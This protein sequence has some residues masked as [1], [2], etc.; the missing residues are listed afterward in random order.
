MPRPAAESNIKLTNGDL[1]V[2]DKNT[3]SFNKLTN[4]YSVSKT[5]RF[6]LRPQF[7]TLEHIKDNKII[8]KGEELKSHYEIFKKILDQVFIKLIDDSLDHTYFDLKLIEQFNDLK[9]KP[10]EQF[11]E[12]DATNL[13]SLKDVMKKQIDKNLDSPEKKSIFK[14]PANFLLDNANQYSNIVDSQQQS[15]EAFKRQKGYLSGYL[16]NRQ[17]IFDRTTNETSVAFRVV[18]DNLPIFINN[19]MILSRF[20][21]T[22][23]DK[24]TLLTQIKSAIEKL[25]ANINFETFFELDYFNRTLSQS[26][27][28]KYNLLISGK[29]TDQNTKLKGINELIKEYIDQHQGEKLKKIKLKKLYKQI[30]S[31][32]TTNSFA[33]DIIDTNEDLM[34]M[35]G[36]FLQLTYERVK[37]KISFLEK[38]ESLKDHNQNSTIDLP[39]VYIE[40][41]NLKRLSSYV[42]KE[43]DFIEQKLEENFVVQFSGKL[44]KKALDSYRKKQN[45]S[46]QEVYDGLQDIQYEV[47]GN[48]VP[49]QDLFLSGIPDFI[50][51]GLDCHLQNLLEKAQSENLLFQEISQ[52]QPKN[53][54]QN[55]FN[56]ST[57]DQ[58]SISGIKE[59]LDFY[60]TFQVN[61]SLFNINQEDGKVE[62]DPEFYSDFDEL[63][64]DL[65]EIIPVYNKARNYLTKKPFSTE[66]TKLTFNN[67][68]LLNG[69]SK[70][71]EKS[72]FGTI[73]KKDQKYY[74]GVINSQTKTKDTLFESHNFSESLQDQDCYEKMSLYFLS[75]LKRDFPHKYFSEKW[76]KKH[77]IPAELHKKYEYYRQD[78]NKDEQ[79]ADLTYHHE[80]I[81]Y[82]QNCLSKDEEC[83]IYNFKLKDP[84]SY[85]NVSDF[86]AD[87]TPNTYRMDFTKIPE[88]YIKKLVDDGKLYFFQLYS[89]DFSENSKGKPNLHTLYL[90]AVFDQ[91]NAEKFNYSYKI[92]GEA[93]IFY[94][95]ASLEC[96]VT[97]EKNKPIQ[98]KNKNNHKKE[99]VFSYDLLKD[100]RYMMD[101]FFLHLPIELN[102]TPLHS[103][104][105]VINQEVNQIVKL[106]SKNYFLG[107]DRGERHLIYLV[108]IDED[109]KIIKQQTLNQISNQYKNQNGETETVTTNYHDLLDAKEKQ[110]KESLQE[111]Q[112]VENI[113]ELKAGFLSN[114]VNEIGKIITEYQPV[115]MLENLNTGFKNSRI[116]IE[117]QVYQKFE[118]ALIDKFNYFIR[119]DLDPES[120]G[121]LYRALQ[122]KKG[123]S[124]QYNGKQNGIIYYIPANYTSNIDP[125]TG[126][127]SSFIP[128]R[129]ESVEKTKDLISKFNSISY[130][131]QEDL[132]CIEVDYQKIRPDTKL[133]DQKV[134]QIYTYGDRFDT[135]RG[136]N[137]Q[138]ISDLMKPNE[139][140][141]QLF[142]EYDINLG[143][144]LKQQI[145][146]QKDAD[147]FRRFLHLLRLTLQM[148]NSKTATGEQNIQSSIRDN[149][150]I[151]SPVKNSRGVFYDSRQDYK[152]W[153]ENADANGA[154]N[155]ARKGLIMLKNLKSGV[156]EKRICDISTEN[157]LK[158]VEEISK[159]NY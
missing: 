156:D 99:S 110:R 137:G 101:K 16:Q 8:Q 146:S 61:L 145:L 49:A 75:D 132:F 125:T 55:S 106:R 84:K 130:D 72:C 147:F 90:K 89:K 26:S 105:S 134:W 68:Y 4:L 13:R 158:F 52:L 50:Y 104:D 140:F 155:I 122:L 79:K 128:T 17:N 114:V 129:Y 28:E 66:K 46:L 150:Y 107:I 157:W 148:R 33:F 1:T 64:S 45:L 15:I 69:W 62:L 53:I 48:N 71:K 36:N 80:L 24:N 120:I 91:I 14:D 113:K 12:K 116:K 19:Q 51:H 142:N 54:E 73:F 133:W 31:E 23:A 115:I 81:A 108:L 43:F 87:L 76:D 117:K 63:Y 149:D 119:K 11:T 32:S 141:K 102:R 42:F 58:K 144:D 27:I 121:G 153:P 154:Y 139:K 85:A 96:K 41:R 40:R 92:S 131:E 30:L 83:Q 47:N 5:L 38:I 97:H 135:Y 56:H 35:I 98:N 67:S 22:I 124:K 77:P 127:I 143:Q 70:R 118:K 138:W 7:S 151:I 103:K 123:Y 94:R 88:G 18:E 2:N 86:L 21:N 100:R 112:T 29:T 25:G 136:K 93:E 57:F 39:Q 20:L 82:Y 78:K 126:F 3:P 44:T 59:I 6:E 10:R 65:R 34:E 60:K 111:W 95:P 159:G 37:E 9:I 109:G 152:D 74:I